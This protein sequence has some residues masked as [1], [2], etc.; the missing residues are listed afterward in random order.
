MGVSFLSDLMMVVAGKSFR[1]TIRIQ[2]L[3][4]F[5]SSFHSF[6]FFHFKSPV[7]WICFSITMATYLWILCTIAARVLQAPHAIILVNK[8]QLLN[9]KKALD[10]TVMTIGTGNQRYNRVLLEICAHRMNRNTQ[11]SL[12]S[13]FSCKHQMVLSD[14]SPQVWSVNVHHPL[15]VKKWLT[16]L[17]FSVNMFA[18]YI[19]F[20]F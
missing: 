17:S 7:D 9:S 12:W 4:I 15:R 19:I 16:V 1:V 20:Q 11:C 14:F 10:E 6:F 3:M 18:K 2:P 8:R 13:P 5:Y